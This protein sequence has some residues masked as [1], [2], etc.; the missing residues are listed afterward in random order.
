MESSIDSSSP[1]EFDQS[2]D[3]LAK[4]PSSEIGAEYKFQK[5][6]GNRGEE[7]VEV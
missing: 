2:I 3:S 4:V 1:F 5:V 7:E 6:E